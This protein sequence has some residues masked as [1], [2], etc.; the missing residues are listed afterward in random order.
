MLN[1][2][3]E[4]L[5]IWPWSEPLYR[6]LLSS[7]NPCVWLLAIHWPV[8]LLNRDR[9]GLA[10]EMVLPL[11]DSL[12]P[13]PQLLQSAR[14]LS[15]AA[16]RNRNSRSAS[17]CCPDLLPVLIDYTA[18]V[19][20]LCTP[21]ERQNGLHWLHD[22]EECS[23]CNLHLKVAARLEK[24]DIQ[25]EL[26]DAAVAIMQGYLTA[27][28]FDHD[29]TQHITL[30]LDALEARFGTQAEQELHKRLVNWTVFEDATEPALRDYDYTRWSDAHLRAR[31]QILLL[32][33][34]LER[35]PQAEKTKKC[36]DLWET[37]V[38]VMR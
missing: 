1:C 2:L 30:Y 29:I 23:W 27:P 22:C 12:E 34:F 24:G 28:H 6:C 13:G 9:G 32:Q 33:A 17:D 10:P 5:S 3:T 31:W 4:H 14:L 15:E 37:R 18:A 26:L 25:D 35:H 19:L 16:F 7:E 20:P 8:F 21:E 38:E 11:M 36:L